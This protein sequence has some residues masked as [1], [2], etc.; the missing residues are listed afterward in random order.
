[1]ATILRPSGIQMGSSIM[2]ISGS[3]P[4]YPS[5]VW[6]NFNGTGTVAI[7]ADGNVS[8]ISDNGTGDYTINF[9]VSLPSANFSGAQCCADHGVK[10]A[11]MYRGTGLPNTVSSARIQVRRGGN[12]ALGD[13]AVVCFRAVT[14]TL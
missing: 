6:V 14:A 3:T 12:H 1:M 2:D 8:T 5:R 11:A 10:F 7:R 13:S 4:S 9:S